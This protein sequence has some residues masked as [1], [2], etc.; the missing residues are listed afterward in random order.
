MPRGIPNTAKNN[1]AFAGHSID[2]QEHVVQEA[3]RRLKSTGAARD[4][5]E[6]RGVQIVE[7]PVDEEKLAMLAFMEE[8]VTVHIHTTSD[9]E[10]EQVFEIFNNGQRE[11][12]R[13]GETKTVKRKF[14][15]ELATRKT[16]T[17]VNQRK[18]DAEG[19]QMEVYVPQTALRYP[20]SVVQD[21]HPRGAD[22]LK[23]TLAMN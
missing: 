2:A 7:R 17:Y 10:A 21:A 4:A 22:W 1:P 16:T 13:R 5:L 20:F 23:A 12:F 3:P 18:R 9:K 19:T 11:V 8:P 14:V 15:N 6:R